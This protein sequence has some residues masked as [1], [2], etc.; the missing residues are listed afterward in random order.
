MRP[1]D[2]KYWLFLKEPVVIASTAVICLCLAQ[3]LNLPQGYWAVM[4]SIIV[5][6]SSV[7]ETI[8]ASLTRLIGTAI[9]AIIGGIFLDLFG[10]HVWVFGIAVML[11][12]LT[13]IL[14]NLKQSY[15]L[16]AVTVGIILLVN[17]PES[18]WMTA[19]HRFLEVSLG[20]VVALVI[21]I[22][23]NPEYAYGFFQKRMK[24]R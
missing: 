13:C 11:V 21:S 6:Q 18:P 23:L 20:V 12:V 5:M 3:W 1:I 24:S 19:F 7:Q 17:H 10:V 16:A 8:S 14:L 9:G 22:V 15:R 2:D 4:S